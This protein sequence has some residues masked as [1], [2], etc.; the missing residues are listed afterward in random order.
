MMNAECSFC[1]QIGFLYS[2]MHDCPT[3]KYDY[4]RSMTTRDFHLVG[5]ADSHI[6][7]RQPVL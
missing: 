3:V 2:K 4:T 5:T 7:I 1:D 6:K